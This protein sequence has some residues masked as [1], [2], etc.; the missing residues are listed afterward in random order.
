MTHDSTGPDGAPPRLTA[1]PCGRQPTALGDDAA[2]GFHQHAGAVY[3]NVT[4]GIG[5][6]SEDLAC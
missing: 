5:E 4:P 6:H 1:K 3:G 2:A